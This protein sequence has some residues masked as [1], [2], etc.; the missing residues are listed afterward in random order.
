MIKIFVQVDLR[1][2]ME[3]MEKLQLGDPL[4]GLSETLTPVG[5]AARP[6]TLWWRGYRVDLLAVVWLCLALVGGP[7]L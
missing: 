4:D 2:R 1:T 7:L 6:S 3:G 5:L